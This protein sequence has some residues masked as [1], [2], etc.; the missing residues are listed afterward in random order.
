[1]HPEAALMMGQPS[2]PGYPGK[3]L[4]YLLKEISN[5]FGSCEGNE[6]AGLVI[7]SQ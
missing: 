1:M 5:T 4:L 7:F 6:V 2:I 3:V